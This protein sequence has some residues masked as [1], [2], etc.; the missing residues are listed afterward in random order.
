[1][2]KTAKGQGARTWPLEPRE[3]VR[4]LSKGWP[5]TDH[6]NLAPRCRGA[7][8]GSL[9]YRAHKPLRTLVLTNT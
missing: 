5:P 8:D 4:G 7:P 3:C 2:L 9:P 6:M 1:M